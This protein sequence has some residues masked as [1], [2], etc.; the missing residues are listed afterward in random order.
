MV[1]CLVV[2]RHAKSDWGD[3]GLADHDRPL[4]RRGRAAAPRIGAWLASRG[5]VPDAALV[6]TAIRARQTWDG[7]APALPAAPAPALD[8]QLYLAEPDTILARLRAARGGTVALVG[9]NPGVAQF[10]GAIVA[11]PPRHDRFED[12]PTSSTLLVAF[13]A[14]AWASIAFGDGDARDFYV[15]PRD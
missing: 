15:P 10:A 4:N 6:S 8:A 9:H 3:P 1:L 5:W 2:I 14:P 7:V 12:F 11:R 13:D